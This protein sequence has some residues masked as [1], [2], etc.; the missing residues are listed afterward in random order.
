VRPGRLR[1][2]LDDA[3]DVVVV[4]DQ[5]HVAGPQNRAQGAGLGRCERLVAVRWFFQITGKNLPDAV[6]NSTHRRFPRSFLRG[7]LSRAPQ[8]ADLK[9]THC[10]LVHW[11]SCCVTMR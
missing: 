10:N 9:K 1:E 2:V 3:E 8:V 7:F 4:F 5:Q 11:L 6:D